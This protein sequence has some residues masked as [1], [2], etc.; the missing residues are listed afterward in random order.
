VS[1][2]GR[3]VTSVKLKVNDTI[4]KLRAGRLNVVGGRELSWRSMNSMNNVPGL[5]A[6]SLRGRTN[7]VWRQ[8]FMNLHGLIAVRL[9]TLIHCSILFYTT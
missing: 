8:L 1:R 7:G 3:F 4:H 2:D 9:T 5:L 6:E